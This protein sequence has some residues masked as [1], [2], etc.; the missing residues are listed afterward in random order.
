MPPQLNRYLR[1]NLVGALGATL[2]LTTLALLNHLAPRH[3]LLTSTLAL[4][5]TLIHNLIW[6]LHYTWRDRLHQ[7]SRLQQ[8]TRFHLAN[9]LT[10]LLGNLA[11]MP[12]LVHKA[13]LPVVA[14]NAIAILAGS[15]LNFA[16]GNRWVFTEHAA[17]PIS[18]TRRNLH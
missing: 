18:T 6:H 10:S 9:G 3:Y 1:F 8:I 12:L 2:Q 7:T 17:A 11:L 14:A 16:A 15:L 4:E 13:H 5:L